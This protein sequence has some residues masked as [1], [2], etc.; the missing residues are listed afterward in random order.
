[1]AE[2]MATLVVQGTTAGAGLTMRSQHP[3]DVRTWFDGREDVRRY[4]PRSR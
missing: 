3:E 1:V 2:R 4:G